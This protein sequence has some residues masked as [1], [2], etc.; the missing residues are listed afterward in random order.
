MKVRKKHALSGDESQV[1]IMGIALW[2]IPLDIYLGLHV[3]FRRETGNSYK[4][5]QGLAGCMVGRHKPGMRMVKG[6]ML[7]SPDGRNLC[8]SF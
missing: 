2:I 7:F 1:S 5:A 4:A 8:S 6:V 3:S